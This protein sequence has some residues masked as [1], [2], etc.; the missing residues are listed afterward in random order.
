[1]TRDSQRQRV[2]DAEDQFGRIL[3]RQ[4]DYPIIEIAG[5]KII[6]PLERKFGQLAN[7]E[8]YVT[9]VCKY[10]GMEPPKVRERRGQTKAHYEQGTIAIPLLDRW[11]MREMVVL[12][13]LAHARTFGENHNWRFCQEELSLVERMMG[14]EASFILKILMMENGVDIFGTE[15]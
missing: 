6:V 2:Y 14:I 8:S 15:T 5:S 3:D 9:Q 7:I 4:Y 11:A 13:E 12:H 1:M 10:L